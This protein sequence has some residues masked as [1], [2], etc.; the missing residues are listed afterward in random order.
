[1]D[2]LTNCQ[3]DD[4]FNWFLSH[5]EISLV[6]GGEEYSRRCVFLILSAFGCN[7][8]ASIETQLRLI[9][10][11]VIS[12]WWCHSSAVE[13]CSWMPPS[14]LLINLFSYLVGAWESF[15]SIFLQQ[16]SMG[17]VCEILLSLN[18]RPYPGGSIFVIPVTISHTAVSFLLLTR[19]GVKNTN[20]IPSSSSLSC[21][22]PRPPRCLVMDFVNKSVGKKRTLC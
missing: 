13:F 6:V 2:T 5:T 10:G 11:R 4:D 1:M 22:S 17:L 19:Q 15:K 7:S 3:V 8:I 14:L 16:K 18:V 9:D 12:E 20:P 21:Q